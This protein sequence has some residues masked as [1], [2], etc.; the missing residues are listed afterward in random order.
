[1]G[2]LIIVSCGK[3]KICDRDPIAGPQKAED[4]YTS[5]YFKKNQEY[6]LSFG[7]DWMIFSAKYGFIPPDFI[8]SENYN[9]T[10]L[11][12]ERRERNVYNYESC[13]FS[14]EK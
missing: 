5:G 1:M 2:V 3:R 14:K 13:S 8:I 4:V 11:C 6:A 9:V 7:N 10:F 12:L